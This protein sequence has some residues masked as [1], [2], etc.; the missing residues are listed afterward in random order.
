MKADNPQ[1]IYIRFYEHIDKYNINL[2]RHTQGAFVTRII[3]LL[4]LDLQL[5]MQ[6]VPITTDVV[7]SNLEQGEVFNIIW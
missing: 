7:N 4:L 5:P 3:W 2:A 6:S 1:W